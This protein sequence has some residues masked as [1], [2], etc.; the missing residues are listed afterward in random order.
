MEKKS[1]LKKIKIAK[2]GPYLVSG[3]VPLAREEMVI[4]EEGDPAA[5]EKGEEFPEAKDYRLCRCGSSKNK[6]FCDGTHI[7][8]VFSDKE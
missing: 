4:G 6:P 8:I 3:N 2:N 7:D 1:S 5:W